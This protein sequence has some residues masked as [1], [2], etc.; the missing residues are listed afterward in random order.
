MVNLRV[1][2]AWGLIEAIS[3]FLELMLQRERERERLP[4]YD[5]LGSSV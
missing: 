4:L 2:P 3:D 1:R 5:K